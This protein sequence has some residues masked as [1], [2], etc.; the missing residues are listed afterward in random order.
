MVLLATLSIALMTLDH[1]EHLADPV[2]DVVAGVVSP[3]R[4]LVDAPFSLAERLS[5]RIAT[6]N[7]LIQRNRELRDQNLLSQERL[8]RM[9]A[10]EREN[11]RLRELLGS[12]KQLDTE[13][14]VTR[15]LQ[16]E[17]D[18]HTHIVEIDRG[19][20]GG[21]FVGQP[22]LDAKGVMG[23]VESVGPYSAT[24]RLISDASHAIPVEVN[25]NGL[26]AIARGN[27]DRHRLTLANV[28]NNA[29]IKEG[30]LL[31][32]SGLGGTFPRGYPVAKVTSVHVE[33]G[34][35]FARV[36]AEPIADLD[37]SRKLMLVAREGEERAKTGDETAAED[38][39]T[40]RREAS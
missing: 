6:R 26:R 29:D 31:T 27:G 21:A 18:P 24:V 2:R 34:E 36:E 9:E 19:S 20:S 30:D 35:P 39:E 11:R 14:I 28:P 1:R 7:Q 38:E 37:R 16:I 8:Q 32:A 12:S 23:Q 17:L 4:I 10:L 22:V 25:R 40:H 33:A 13:V 3:V 5:E 15:L